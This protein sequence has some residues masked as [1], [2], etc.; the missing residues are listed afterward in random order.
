MIIAFWML[1]RNFRYARQAG[2]PRKA[3]RTEAT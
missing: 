2:L 1:D 3:V